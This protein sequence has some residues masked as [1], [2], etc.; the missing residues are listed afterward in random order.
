[1]FPNPIVCV[2]MFGQECAVH[3]F[4]VAMLLAFGSVVT[5][6]LVT[7]RPR[8]F[9]V[10]LLVDLLPLVVGVGYLVSIA[11]RQVLYSLGGGVTG[12]SHFL[13]WAMGACAAIV[14]HCR[15]A[16]WQ[17]P[18]VLD[19]V[20]LPV[21]LASGI[22]RLGC[23]CAGCCSGVH[24]APPLGI[25]F[26]AHGEGAPTCFPAQ[27]LSSALDFAAFGVLLVQSRRKRLRP[28][29]LAIRVCIA[30][31]SVRF[32]VEFVRTE[33]RLLFG[34]SVA[35]VLCCLAL[36]VAVTARRRLPA[37]MEPTAATRAGTP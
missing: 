23:F 15:R 7:V 8:R 5:W 18:V 9:A 11:S 32:C 2:R 33:P 4:G 16:G 31:C 26:P 24:C 29:E 37:A 30:Y 20:M 22:G 6:I 36:S 10:Q 28:G 34:L 12:G 19:I 17:V 27:L 3:W 21:L 1:M 25:C 14:W 35:Q 13:G